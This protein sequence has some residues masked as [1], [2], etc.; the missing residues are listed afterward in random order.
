MFDCS[1]EGEYRALRDHL[2]LDGPALRNL[3]RAGI[4]SSWASPDKKAELRAG[5]D[6][7]WHTR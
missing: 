6:A 1:L 7:R 5:L 2:G 3:A 4:E